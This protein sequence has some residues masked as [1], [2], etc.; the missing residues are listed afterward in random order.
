[1]SGRPEHPKSVEMEKLKES[2]LSLE[3]NDIEKESLIIQ[4]A[5]MKGLFF[6]KIQGG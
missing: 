5:D 6:R 1:M 2:I 3:T 4:L